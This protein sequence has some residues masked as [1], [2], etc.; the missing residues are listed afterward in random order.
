MT[1][2]TK[3][4]FTLILFAGLSVSAFA[5]TVYV[6]DE[7]RVGIRPEPDIGYSPVGVVVTGMKLDVLDRQA[8]F[9]KIKTDDGMIGWIKDIYATDKKPAMLRL[10]QLQKKHTVVA[11]QLKEI[12]KDLKT[13]ESSNQSLNEQVE[14]LKQERAEWQLLQAKLASSQQQA[15]STWYWWFMALVVVLVGSFVGGIQWHRIQA[16]KRL[17]G[18]RV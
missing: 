15:K 4:L 7:L 9:V 8:G 2:R 1:I 18:L 14:E 3:L 12:S 10:Q 16:M 11:N 5:E 13:L 17:G 6:S